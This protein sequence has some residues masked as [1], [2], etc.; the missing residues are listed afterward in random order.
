MVLSA[1]IKLLITSIAIAV[2]FMAI[3]LGLIKKDYLTVRYA[4]VWF[5]TGFIF[6]TLAVFPKSM[7]F[8]STVIGI[9]IPVNALFFLGFMVI[10][11]ILLALTVSLS[12]LSR[13]NKRLGQEIAIYGLYLKEIQERLKKDT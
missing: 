1:D 5:A 9:V 6:L 12:S 3:V 2:G 11:V 10:L 8:I 7:S 13:A 4:L